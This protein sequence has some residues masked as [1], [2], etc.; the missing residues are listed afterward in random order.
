M[1]KAAPGRQEVGRKA[2]AQRL[3]Y[4]RMHEKVWS[5]VGS[6]IEAGDVDAEQLG[7]RVSAL[8]VVTATAR[9]VIVGI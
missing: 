1:G 5:G 3:E 2:G 4:G 8:S 9:D 6:A 7:E